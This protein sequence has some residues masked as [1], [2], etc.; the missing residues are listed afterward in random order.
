MVPLSRVKG[1]KESGVF[2]NTNQY[3]AFLRISWLLFTFSLF[4]LTHTSDASIRHHKRHV[5]H[6]KFP[7]GNVTVGLHSSTIDE[8]PWSDWSESSE[9]TRTCGGGVAFQTRT[10][11]RTIENGLP[12]CTG[13]SKRYLSCNIQD[14]PEG[15][16]DFRETQCAKFDSIPFGGK[17]FNWI[18]YKKGFN[19]CELNCMPKGGDKF[20]YRH[21]QAVLDGTRCREDSL[22]VCVQGVCMAVGCDMMLGS[23][24]KED[25]CQECGGDG[26]NCKTI[27][28]VFDLKN[29]QVGYNDIILIPTGATSIKIKELEPS[30]NYLAIRNSTGYYY[31]NGNWQ[32]EFPRTLKFAGSHFYYERVPRGYVGQESIEAPGPITEPIYISLLYQQKNL[33]ISYEYSVPLGISNTQPDNYVWVYS[34]FG[35]CSRSCG[36]GIQTRSVNC[37][38]SSSYEVVADYLCDVAYKPPTNQT[39]NLIPC[40]A[41]WH[42][43]TWDEC[44]KSCDGGVQYRQV[45]CQR[46]SQG[47]GV[48]V[49]DSEC[50]TTQGAK[51]VYARACNDNPCPRWKIGEWSSCDKLCGE[52]IQ[53]REVECN[54]KVADDIDKVISKE[55]CKEEEPVS[56]QVCHLRPCEETEWIVSEWSGCDGVCGLTME[57]RAAYCASQDGKIHD[58][59][60]CIGKIKPSLE[61]KCPNHQHCESMWHA[62]EWSECSA[63]CGRGMKTRTVF[64]GSWRNGEIHKVSDDLCEASKKMKSEEECY[65]NR[66]GGTWFTGPWSRCSVP[67]GGGQQKRKVMCV[68]QDAIVSHSRCDIQSQPDDVQPCHMHPCDEDEVMIVGGCHKSKYGCCPDG[69]TTAGRND[70]GCPPDTSEQ[71][72]TKTEFGCCVDGKT[73]AAGPFGKGCPRTVNCNETKY[74]CCPDGITPSKSEDLRG[75]YENCEDSLWGCCPDGFTPALGTNNEGCSSIEISCKDSPFGCCPDGVTHATG[76]DYDGC[77]LDVS[78]GEDCTYSEHGCCPDGITPAEGKNLEGCPEKSRK[79]KRSHCE[80]SLYGCCPDGVTPA[81]GK[82]YLGCFEGSGDIGNDCQNTLYGCCPDDTTAAEGPHFA[83]CPIPKS[84]GNHTHHEEAHCSRHPYGCCRDGKSVAKGPNYL[85]CRDTES[86]FDQHCSNTVFGCCFDGKTPAQGPNKFGCCHISQ[87]G[88]CPDNVTVASGPYHAGCSCHTYP[89]GCCPDGVTVSKGPRF[90]GCS[91]DHSAYGCCQ[92]GYSYAKGPNFEGCDCKNTLY[93]CC[94]DNLTPAMGPHGKGCECHN[95]RFG[96]CPDGVMPAFGANHTGCPCKTFPYGCCADGRTVAKGPNAEDCPCEATTHGCCPDHKTAARG[97]YNEGCPCH[98]LLHGCCPDNQTAA[99]GPNYQGC[100]CMIMPFGCCPDKQMAASGPN[101]Q[102]CPCKSMLYGCCPDGKTSAQGPGY[103][104]CPCISFPYGCCPDGITPARDQNFGGCKGPKK[105]HKNLVTSDVCS[106][107]KERGPC[108]NFTVKWYFDVTYGGC[109]RFWYGGCDGNGNQFNS[110]DA[111]EQVCVNPEGPEACSLPKVVGPCKGSHPSWYYE[112]E[113]DSCKSFNYSGCLGNNNRYKS[114]EICENICVKQA[115]L[116]TCDQPMDVGPCK[117]VTQRWF[118]NKAENACK[119]FIY[120]GCKGNS[121]NFESEK[122][123]MQRC[124]IAKPKD[125]ATVYNATIGSQVTMVC[126]GVPSS[127]NDEILLFLWYKGDSAYP[128]HGVDR[129]KTSDAKSQIVSRGT[130]PRFTVQEDDHL[131]AL[132]IHKVRKEDEGQYRCRIDYK[133]APTTNRFMKLIISEPDVCHL[134]QAIGNCYQFRERWYYNS[135]ERKCQ[136]F[137]YSGCAGNENNFATFIECEKQCQKPND[138]GQLEE[139]HLE[140]CLMEPDA[141]PCDGRKLQWFYDKD[142]VCKQFYYGGCRGNANR[143]NTK[144]E[145]EYK[146]LASQDVCKLPKIRGPCSGSF[147]QWY[148]DKEQGECKEFSYS[149]CQGNGNRFNDKE[150]CEIQCRSLPAGNDQESQDPCSQQKD[151]GPCLGYFVMWYHDPEDN[152]CKTFVYGGCLGNDNRF[153]NLQEC[154]A[155]CHSNSPFTMKKVKPVQPST[156]AATFITNEEICRQKPDEGHCS[157]SQNRFYYEPMKSM[158]L[159]FVYKGCGGNKNRFKTADLCMRFCSGVQGPGPVRDEAVGEAAPIEQN[160][161]CP[162]SNCDQL[163]CP[164]GIEEII[165]IRGCTSCL[166]TNPCEGHS[167]PEGSQCVVE[168]HR[169]TNGDVQSQPLCRL[170]SKRGQCPAT[171]PPEHLLNGTCHD[172]CQSDADCPGGLKCCFVSCAKICVLPS[173]PGGEERIQENTIEETDGEERIQENT[174]EETETPR[175]PQIFAARKDIAVKKGTSALLRCIVKGY[176]APKITWTHR[177]Q[178]L[179]SDSG[180]YKISPDGSLH[181]MSVGDAHEGMYTCSAENGIGKPVTRFFNLIVFV[182]TQINITL[183][184]PKYKVNSTLQLDCLVSGT[185]PMIVSWHLGKDSQI[186]VSDSHRM[187]FTNHTLFIAS[188]QYNDSGTYVCEAQNRHGKASASMDIRVHDISVPSTCKDSPFFTSCAMIVKQNYCINPTYAKYCCLSCAISGQLLNTGDIVS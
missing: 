171:P 155:K 28:G 175:P 64:C 115:A 60:M 183:A 72:C 134:P 30:N 44:S 173:F 80:S 18:P 113:T 158:C 131:T 105:V 93:G 12:V 41:Q 151:P 162:T 108:H 21:S 130:D 141:G 180:D 144:K 116:D 31:L 170:K 3:F 9:C 76:S 118:F 96:C 107:P 65:G 102:G 127:P 77:D 147:P 149:G 47:L 186:L 166:C 11:T 129:R 66:C 48:V 83:G 50:S 136:R 62:S 20:Y 63:A 164:H 152:T 70:E 46:E 112:P 94:P 69:V 163:Q 126:K 36:G 32:I 81:D 100:P 124:V 24:V 4:L 133:V 150:T 17:Y 52:G 109:S 179:D 16:K 99:Q 23:D 143:F 174:I 120:G 29:L 167:C 51:P 177:N 161:N 153:S 137:Y 8:G 154:D 169:T 121:N 35:A 106:L 56:E 88:C 73:P 165:D 160:R 111:C 27:E 178:P 67:C 140:Y 55:F 82:D 148:F 54:M 19:E 156:A 68:F 84:H 42:V 157:Y 71:N 123:C 45:H 26:S 128:I 40:A 10:C 86:S 132:T 103:E 185:E 104:G 184:T 101:F 49:P 38:T 95:L 91:C 138:K 87:Y 5:T 37:A 14:C 7:D 181:I 142:G 135:N 172:R 159:P 125:T 53:R 59:K 57:S 92:D 2:H 145:C 119:A 146:C 176:P 110:Q 75:C 117:K 33:G 61:R 79:G 58:E 25:K 34:N 122:E 6:H 1:I 114:K 187:I 43:S 85:G 13:P 139:F 74:G 182:D 188:A 15:S 39:C 89:H 78:S 90:E 98:S 22:D 97:P 168:K